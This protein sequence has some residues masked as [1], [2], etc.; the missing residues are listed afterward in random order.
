[1]II[2]LK[3][4]NWVEFIKSLVYLLLIIATVGVWAADQRYV[5]VNQLKQAVQEINISRLSHEI[6]LLKIKVQ[7]N[8]ATKSEKI[9]LPLL[10]TELETL[11]RKA[12]Q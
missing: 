2:K 9:I 10:E 6:A 5:Q 3:P 4:D 7:Q 1:M 11:K 12:E 8:E